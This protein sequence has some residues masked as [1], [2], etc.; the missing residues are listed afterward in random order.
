MSSIDTIVDTLEQSSV[1]DLLKLIKKASDIIDKK[2]K[3]AV[4][5]ADKILA[6]ANKTKK[7]KDPDAPKK[8]MNAYMFFMNDNRQKIKAD[9]GDDAKS[10]DVTKE[11]GNRWNN[12][13]DKVKAKYQK[14][15]DAD[16][17]RYT[18]A[19]AAYHP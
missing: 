9:L 7:Q 2:F 18:D 8:P 3:N 14:M 4:K 1:S 10:T 19:I 15:A 13:T 5:D 12:A 16:K 6:K 17:K 11:G